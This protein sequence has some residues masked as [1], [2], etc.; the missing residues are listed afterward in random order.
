MAT[1]ARASALGAGRL[2]TRKP[3]SARHAAPVFCGAAVLTPRLRPGSP[4]GAAPRRA[5]GAPSRRPLSQPPTGVAVAASTVTEEWLQATGVP[6][7]NAMQQC[8]SLS[9]AAVLAVQVAGTVV[10]GTLAGRALLRFLD[11]Q[12]IPKGCRASICPPVSLGRR[13]WWAHSEGTRVLWRSNT[14]QAR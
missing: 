12:V 2:Q 13:R 8:A 14:V 4:A 3:A 5:A 7:L 1:C 9:Q 10:V 11:K 6:L